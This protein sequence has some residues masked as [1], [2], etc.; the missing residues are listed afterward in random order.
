MNEFWKNGN[1]MK[2]KYGKRE[3]INDLR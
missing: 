2:R 3:E 1:T